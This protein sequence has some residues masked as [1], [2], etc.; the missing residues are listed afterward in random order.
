LTNS[1]SD[2]EVEVTGYDVKFKLRAIYALSYYLFADLGSCYGGSR[3]KAHHH[4]SAVEGLLGVPPTSRKPQPSGGV[5][6]SGART[7]RSTSAN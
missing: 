2:D 5:I 3:G 6:S 1:S 7:I 4:P